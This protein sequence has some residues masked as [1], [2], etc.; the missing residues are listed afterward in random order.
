MTIVKLP[1]SR[2]WRVDTQEPVA[3][4]YVARPL[5]FADLGSL[6]VGDALPEGRVTPRRIQSWIGSNRVGVAFDT[7]GFDGDRYVTSDGRDLDFKV[8]R[9]FMWSG[10][11]YNPGDPAPRS[12]LGQ[13]NALAMLLMARNITAVLDEVVEDQGV[14]VDD[15]QVDV[16]DPID[17]VDPVNPASDPVA[18]AKAALGIDIWPAGYDLVAATSN[19]RYTLTTPDGEVQIRGRAAVVAYLGRT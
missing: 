1:V 4:Y 7:G 15:L 18:E 10:E 5:N 11:Q 3:L 6:R 19:G 17:P 14:D 16:N 2:R 13:S 9:A 12:L 8:L